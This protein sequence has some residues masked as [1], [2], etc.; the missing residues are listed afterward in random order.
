MEMFADDTKMITGIDKREKK[1]PQEQQSD[2]D[3]LAPWTK[4]WNLHFNPHMY[5]CANGEKRNND[6]NDNNDNDNNNNNDA[7][8]VEDD[9][10]EE[11]DDDSDD[12]D[13]PN[14]FQGR[15]TF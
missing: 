15:L 14:D 2:I 1:K 5:T 11:D 6:G 3:Q 4:E 8:D 9:K 12:D 13:D 7:D 10:G